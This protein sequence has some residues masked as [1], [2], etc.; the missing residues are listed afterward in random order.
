MKQFVVMSI[1]A[2]SA[3]S[4]FALPREVQLQKGESQVVCRSEN[5]NSTQDEFGPA[6]LNGLLLM[7]EISV[8]AADSG[9]VKVVI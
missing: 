2:L 8:V 1:V 6:A 5:S 7:Q 9:P 4:V 3:S